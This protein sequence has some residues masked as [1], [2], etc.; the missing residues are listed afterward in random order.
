MI[1]VWFPASTD[2]WFSS[3]S[4]ALCFERKIISSGQSWLGISSRKLQTM[5]AGIPIEISCP[6]VK[7]L[8]DEGSEFVF[9]DCREADEYEAC[10]IPGAML[11]PMSET[12][13]RI[14]ELSEHTDKLIVVHCH[15]GGRS[16]RV[17]GFLR[18]NGY[19]NARSMAGGIDE[20][21]QTIDPSIPRY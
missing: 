11:L 10:R 6:E 17:A 15:H 12:R 4:F 8:Q 14:D 21:S 7:T 13:E 1:L 16:L 5:N 19:P 2:P 3:L 9:I 20:W 18:Q